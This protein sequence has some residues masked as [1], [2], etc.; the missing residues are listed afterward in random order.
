[1]FQ[2]LFSGVLQFFSEISRLFLWASLLG[3]VA[4]GAPVDHSKYIPAQSNWAV[5]INMEQLQAKSPEWSDL[6][7]QDIPF[8]Q[9]ASQD[10]IGDLF[11]SS[12]INFKEKAF[13]F[14]NMGDGRPDYYIALTFKLSNESA[15]DRFLRDLPNQNISISSFSGMRF[16]LI[17]DKTILG[18]SNRVAYLISKS[19]NYT[20]RSLKDQ[21]LR[22]RDLPEVQSL[23]SQNEQFRRIRLEKNDLN[24][25]IDVSAF[26]QEFRQVFQTFPLPLNPNLKNNYLTLSSDF[27]L[28][29]INSEFKLFNG[30]QSLTSYQNLVKPNI[31]PNFISN[32]PLSLPMGFFSFGLNPGELHKVFKQFGGGFFEK[33]IQSFAGCSSQE[34]L[35]IFDGDIITMVEDIK[36]N[37]EDSLQPYEFLLGLG[38]AQ[39]REMDSLLMHFRETGFLVAA[40]SFDIFPRANWYVL[41]KRDILFL[42]PSDSIRDH[43]LESQGQHI[44]PRIVKLSQD[45]FFLMYLDVQ[46]DTRQK[47]PSTF[48]Q[49]DRVSEGVFKN[50]ETPFESLTFNI[51][52]FQNKIN[53]SELI[54][55]LSD[56]KNNALELLVEAFRNQPSN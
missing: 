13:L 41:P 5:C 21:L 9:I 3:L 19:R 56:K 32:I 53:H 20:L 44:V 50:T 33:S 12:G 45:S 34:L 42:T 22:L 6:L 48:F 30:N 54:I 16:T 10:R 28:G 8:L 23:K 37:P 7:N 25:W 43:L 40:D 2:P 47:I 36:S 4:C 49:E 17:N 31:D 35:D 27:N 52:P 38:I 29:E 14:S 51:Q 11:K 1:M 46:K 18:W 39:P 55:Q 15:F 24:A 26:G